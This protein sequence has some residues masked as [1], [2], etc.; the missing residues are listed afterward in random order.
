MKYSA[1]SFEKVKVHS[2]G[3]TYVGAK[4]LIDDKSLLDMVTT[5][6][7]PYDKKIAGNYEFQ[8]AEWLYKQLVGECVNDEVDGVALL[9][10]TCGY[11]GCW[12]FCVIVSE[13][14]D[15]VI[16]RDFHNGHREDWDYSALGEIYFEKTLYNIEIEKLKTF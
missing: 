8:S 3:Q 11:D 16:W 2:T 15:A 7:K 13:E 4:I 14:N 10:C 12:S 9:T 5:I 1:L 6:E